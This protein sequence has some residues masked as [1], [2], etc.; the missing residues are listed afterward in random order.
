MRLKR[1]HCVLFLCCIVMVS[2]LGMVGACR[3]SLSAADDQANTHFVRAMEYSNQWW[4]WMEKLPEDGL[5]AEDRPTA[6]EWRSALGLLER[7]LD[8]ATQVSPHFME[9]VHPE[10]R[11]MWVEYK[12]PA[13]EGFL[14]YYS[15]AVEDPSAVK[16]P[17]TREGSEQLQQLLAAYELYSSWVDWYNAN[18]DA[19]RAGIHRLVK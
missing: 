5:T 19:I 14:S 18:V 8:E 17:W 1:W 16:W 11:S 12:I 6:D 3:R 10:L 15:N 9:R 4:D 13:M 2:L 7:A